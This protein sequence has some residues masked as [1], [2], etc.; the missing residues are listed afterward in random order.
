MAF[1]FIL[2]L[3]SFKAN[4]D[5]YSFGCA[6]NGRLGLEDYDSKTSSESSFLPTKLSIFSM[7]IKSI[8]C[9]DFHSAAID[10]FGSFYA[11]GSNYEGQLGVNYYQDRF[12]PERVLSFYENELKSAKI[13]Q[14]RCG[15]RFTGI[16]TRDNTLYMTGKNKFGVLAQDPNKQLFTQF[17]KVK[18]LNNIGGIACGGYHMLAIDKEKK[19]VFSWGWNQMGQLG[20]V[21]EKDEEFSIKNVFSLITQTNS[22]ILQIEAGLVHSAMLVF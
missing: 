14:V 21:G 16:I 5:L 7:N 11:W 6:L 10:E 18:Q 2:I 8:S 9:G 22:E 19:N 15:S 1:Y 13:I 4:G 12:T 17:E 3:K 20:A